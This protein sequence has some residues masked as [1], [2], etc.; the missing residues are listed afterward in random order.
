MSFISLIIVNFN[1]RSF[2]GELLESVASQSRPADEVLLVDN[3]STDGSLDYIRQYFPWVKI[4]SLDSNLGFAQ[5]NNTGLAVAKGDLIALLNSDTIIDKDYLLE[6]SKALEADDRVGAVVPKIYDQDS[7]L[8]FHCAG[9]EFNN[10]GHCWGRGFNQEETGQ[11]E[12]L[13]EVPGVTGCAALLRRS[14]LQGETLFDPE[15]F[16]YLEEFELSLRLRSRGFAIQFVPA[17]IAMHRG[18]QSVRQV[19]PHVGLFG[20]FYGNR[21]RA[22]ILTKYYPFSLLLKN[23]PLIFLSFLYWDFIFLRKAGPIFFLRAVAMQTLFAFKGSWDRVRGKGVPSKGW[24]PW[25]THHGWK[26]L[27]TFKR[28]VVAQQG[29]AALSKWGKIKLEPTAEN[30]G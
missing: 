9:A 13:T 26:Q 4:I 25:M 17:A 7:T 21:N 28:E 10:L 3:A 6:M 30:T 18:S 27:L 16:M 12:V 29:Y 20:Q 2:I 5:G 22:K 14:A 23:F 1:G 15:F 11:F 19:T 8:K 24:L